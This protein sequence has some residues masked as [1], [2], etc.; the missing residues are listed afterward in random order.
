[1][2]NILVLHGFALCGWPPLAGSISRP[3][4]LL[5]QTLEV[6]DSRWENVVTWWSTE[7]SERQYDGIIGLLQGSDG[8]TSASDGML[9]DL[10]NHPEC[11]PGFNPAKK[12]DFKFGIFCSGYIW[13][14]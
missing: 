7:L 4:W 6:G 11:V 8:G 10:V 5:G 9:L 2:L 13:D 3:W 14:P 12:Q 1:M